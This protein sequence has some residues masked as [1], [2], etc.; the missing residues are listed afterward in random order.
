MQKKLKRKIFICTVII[1][2]VLIIVA[3]FIFNQQIRKEINIAKDFIQILYDNNMVSDDRDIDDI[4][5]DISKQSDGENDFYSITSKDFCVDL[6][7]KGR[8]IGFNYNRNNP[9]GD[10]IDADVARN[11]AEKYVSILASGDYKFKEEDNQESNVTYYSYVFTKYKGGFP[12]YND[13]IIIQVDKYSGYLTRYTNV[14]SQNKP[15][16]IEINIKKQDAESI[17]LNSFNKLNN[18]GS[19]QEGE[20]YTAFCDNEDKTETELC[21]VVSVV[22]KDMSDKEVK[23]K[24][25]VSTKSGKVI[26]TLKDNV[27]TSAS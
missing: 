23:M 8:V 16:K 20:I 3:I 25:F 9:L 24:V 14:E 21:Y 7:E 15:E 10:I 22:G 6:N 19:V 17:A 13:Q 2:V 18:D 5:F 26:N 27:S 12:F 1:L 4:K 11:I